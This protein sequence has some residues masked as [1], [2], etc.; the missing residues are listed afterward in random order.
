MS[1]GAGLCRPDTQNQHLI[2][3]FY[4]CLGAFR[5]REAWDWEVIKQ[6]R[7]TDEAL[8]CVR[9]RAVLLR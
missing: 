3:S 7:E 1:G 4:I 5:H 8:A 6:E 2:A 9:S